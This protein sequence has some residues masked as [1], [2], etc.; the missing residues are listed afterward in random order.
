MVQLEAR[1]L[2]AAVE[3]ERPGGYSF[4]KVV[5]VAQELAQELD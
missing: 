2:A 1:T 5:L 3:P 4:Q